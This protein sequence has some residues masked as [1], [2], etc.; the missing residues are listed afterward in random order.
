LDPTCLG[1]STAGASASTERKEPWKPSAEPPRRLFIW[2]GLFGLLVPPAF[3]AYY[4]CTYVLFL[5]LPRNSAAVA[6]AADGASSSVDGTLL[7]W[8]WFVIGAVGTNVSTYVLAGVEA[9]IL[10]SS[11]LLRLN[12]GQA[13]MHKD[14]SWSKVSGW[15]DMEFHVFGKRNYGNDPVMSW[16]WVVLFVLQLLSWAFVLSGLTME[17]EASFRVGGAPGASVVG[18]NASTFDGRSAVGVLEAAYQVWRLGQK[19]QMP[20]LGAFYSPF[21][22]KVDFNLTI[23]N[24]LPEYTEEAIFLAPQADMPLSGRAWGLVFNYS[25]KPIYKLG[26]F[27]ILNHRINS[28]DPRYFSGVLISPQSGQIYRDPPRT[29]SL[30]AHYFYDV[31]GIPGATISVVRENSSTGL[32]LSGIG[33]V[34]E[35]G[36]SFGVYDMMDRHTRSYAAPYGGLG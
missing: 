15:V 22:Q 17:T 30:P 13:E 9:G 7:W 20:L 6:A 12:R 28:S 2:R 3:A 21:G 1:S 35:A 29:Y 23:V 31:P 10:T 14:R 24:N 19:P 18:A 26:D 36:L 8:S 16:L 25:C 5:R 11:R 4:I 32:G 34:A 33:M 27:Q